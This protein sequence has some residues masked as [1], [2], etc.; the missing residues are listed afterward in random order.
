MMPIIIHKRVKAVFFDLSGV[1]YEG[2]NVIE[3]ALNCIQRLRERGLQL[4]FVTNTASQTQYQL[5][6]QLS[7]MGFKISKRELFTATLAAKSYIQQ[8]RLHPFCIVHPNIEQEFSSQHD[9]PFDSV[10]IGDAR[11]AINYSNLNDAFQLCMEGNPLIGIGHNKYFK[12][13]NG[14]QLDAGA[15]IH[16]IEYATDKEAITVGKPDPTFFQQ[17]IL[18]TGL[19]AEACLMIG[20]DIYGDIEGALNAHMDACLVKTGKYRVNDE[21]K[22]TPSC[23]VISS[24]ATLH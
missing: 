9:K 21:H 5:L 3:G 20:D 13:D 15:F 11:Q 12:G 22:L 7:H 1:L 6:Q 8:Q 18:S 16:L 17:A 4:R 24:I 2:E 10:L 19:N 14:L 23:Q